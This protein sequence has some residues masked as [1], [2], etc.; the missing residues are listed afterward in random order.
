MLVVVLTLRVLLPLIS[1]GVAQPPS[2]GCFPAGHETG[3]VARS[4]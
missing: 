3:L 2:L 1:L 4:G